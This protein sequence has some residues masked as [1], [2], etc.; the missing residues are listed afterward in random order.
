MESNE[1]YGCVMVPFVVSG[2]GVGWWVAMVSTG[3]GWGVVLCG[4]WRS[5]RV[6]LDVVVNGVCVEERW[7][8]IKL[9]TQLQL[10][11]DLAAIYTFVEVGCCW[12][13]SRATKTKCVM[14]NSQL[15]PARGTSEQ[16]LLLQV[17]CF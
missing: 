6:C 13:L 7:R 3:D 10:L 1:R 5:G 11:R 4:G 15:R 12:L 17:S 8:W 16:C 9:A 14:I 2:V